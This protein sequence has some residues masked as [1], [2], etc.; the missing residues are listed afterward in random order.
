MR[1][2][3]LGD[4]PARGRAV[5][6]WMQRAQRG[7]DN[8][9]L[10]VAIETGN[11]LGL[12]VA[13][14]FGLHPGYP[15]ANAR[16]YAFLLDGV[17]ETARRCEA[18]GAAFAFRPY[19][20]HSILRFCD[21]VGA[22]VLIGDE[23]PLREPESWRAAA[24]RRLTIPF[25]TVDADVIVPSSHFE[26]EEWAARTLRPKITKLLPRYLVA[27]GNPRARTAWP[28]GRKP[29]SAPID[30]ASL[31]ATLPLDRGAAPVPG[32]RGGAG[33]A[34]RALR[35]FLARGLARYHEDRNDP[36]RDGTSRLSA[37]LHFGQIGPHT[38][39]LAVRRAKAPRAAREAYLEELIV[40]RE[41][42]VNFALRNPAYDSFASAPAW[43]RASL[44]KHAKDPRPHRYDEAAL[45]AA[46]THDPLWNA[47]QTEMAA[48]GRMHGWL[49]MYWAKKILEWTE[50]AE[51]A[52]SIA[53][54]LNDR[55]LLDGRDPNGYAGIAWAIAGKHDRP[56][57]PDK[58][59]IG[60]LRPMTAAGAARKFDVGAA[61]AR[62]ARDASCATLSPR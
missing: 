36:A 23:N 40:R 15:R 55:Y 42:A 60:L 14:H 1:A 8:P 5:V 17:E 27:V 26:R 59:V 47:A 54:R 32:A 43:A 16:H 10:N 19:P 3:R 6:Y 52:Y 31:L 4:L 18:R 34:R 12:P 35:R 49:R 28:R 37:Y 58:P 45:E 61:I 56:W 51:A 30:A 2:R 24:A 48:T 13:V 53:V 25:L 20:D 33:A 38:V 39:A 9:A 21:E 57:A 46:A 62:I 22:A 41:L 44:A 11:R 50:S 29:A 7:V